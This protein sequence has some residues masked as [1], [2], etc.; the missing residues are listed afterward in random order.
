[1]CHIIDI[2]A[3]EFQNCQMEIN[4]ESFYTLPSQQTTNGRLQSSY[5]KHAYGIA[6]VLQPEND[7]QCCCFDRI[8]NY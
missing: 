1:M 8:D 2:I 4:P 3:S 6:K 5:W 7:T